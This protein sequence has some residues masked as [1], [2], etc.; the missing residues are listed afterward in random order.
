MR[1]VEDIGVMPNI[2]ELEL[3]RLRA[4]TAAE[5]L[6]VS[7]GLW[8]DARKMTRAMIAMRH[9]EWTEGQVLQETR[10]VMTGE[11]A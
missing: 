8:H 11:R 5:K 7:N 3:A 4:M 10:R 9:P 6:R 2:P 1:A